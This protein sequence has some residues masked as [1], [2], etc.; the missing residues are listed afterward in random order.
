MLEK[1]RK[2]RDA[3]PTFVTPFPFLPY[4]RGPFGLTWVGLYPVP[5]PTA[6]QSACEAQE[7]SS[8]WQPHSPSVR[9]CPARRWRFLVCLIH[10][11]IA[12]GR[13]APCSQCTMGGTET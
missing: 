11:A 12:R 4:T 6:T 9:M 7:P 1:L 2:V 5:A 8:S 10:M 3:H 13:W